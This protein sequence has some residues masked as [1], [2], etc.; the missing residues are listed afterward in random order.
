MPNALPIQLG[1]TPDSGQLG[2]S[3]GSAGKP[4]SHGSFTH[5]LSQS[6]RGHAA[7]QAPSGSHTK[8]TPAATA[9][10]PGHG[11]AVKKS[12][13]HGQE[14]ASAKPSTA[15]A[16][17][18]PAGPPP[19]PVPGVPLKGGKGHTAGS[20]NSAGSVGHPPR[21]LPIPGGL[22]TRARPMQSP[23]QSPVKAHTPVTHVVRQGAAAASRPSEAQGELFPP[24]PPGSANL[25]VGNTASHALERTGPSATRSSA[26]GPLHA[27]VQAGVQSQAGVE[28]PKSTGSRNK[29]SVSVAGPKPSAPTSGN[30]ATPGNASTPVVSP[31]SA[32]HG[33]GGHGAPSHAGPA[34]VQ[35][36]TPTEPQPPAWKVQ[37]NGVVAQD[38]T[39]RSSWT[40]QPP[41][42]N[43]PAMKLE[44]TQNGSK[45]KAD[46]TVSPQVMGLINAS[47]TA[48]PHHAVHLPEGVSTLEFSLFTQ[49]GGTGFGEQSAQAGSGQPGNAPVPYQSGHAAPMGAA[50]VE[51]VGTINNGI[52]YRA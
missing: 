39:K 12:L 28:S 1:P 27:E 47:P 17:A 9:E 13:Q 29:A 31:M 20:A 38:G 5:V 19:A 36:K 7:G 24:E 8:A 46:L 14:T 33:H 45:L 49:G 40:I 30:G 18:V 35:T 50:L 11:H 43:A 21:R 4:S 42:T 48:L 41:L 51:S 23:T 3:P 25:K 15:A 26:A 10:A 37:S 44:L 32:S 16:V 2:K 52:D 22:A 34:L 6:S